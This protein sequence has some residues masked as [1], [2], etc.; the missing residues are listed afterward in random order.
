[1]FDNKNDTWRIDMNLRLF[2]KVIPCL[3]IFTHMCGSSAVKHDPQSFHETPVS[4]PDQAIYF[5]WHPPS[6]NS[7]VPRNHSV[8][9]SKFL[10][11]P[12]RYTTDGAAYQKKYQSNLISIIDRIKNSMNIGQESVGFYH[13]RQAN[14]SQ[15]L[16]VGMDII[17]EDVAGT[18]YGAR[19][20]TVIYNNLV[21]VMESV[22]S[23]KVIFREERITGMVVNFKWG[24]GEQ[25]NIWIKAV[26]VERYLNK[27]FTLNEIVQRS[28]LTDGQGKRIILR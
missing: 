3:V 14:N 10:V 27:E 15:R 23:Q 2:R 28:E 22:N 8:D 20:K 1:M 7:I 4:I 18:D 12:N 26:D 25:V 19:A 6:V 11:N 24:S 13:D 9:S 16:Y 21:P 5:G 17:M